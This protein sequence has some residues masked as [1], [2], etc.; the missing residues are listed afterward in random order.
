M[1]DISAQNVPGLE[2]QKVRRALHD[3][4]NLFTGILVHAGLLARALGP[5]HPLH[6]HALEVCDGGERGAALVREACDGLTA[7]EQHGCANG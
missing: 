6:F 7:A 2:A 1:S 3:L 5:E 4:S